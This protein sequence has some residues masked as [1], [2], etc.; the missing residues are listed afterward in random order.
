VT[1][2]NE[3]AV[4]SHLREAVQDFIQ[5]VRSEHE[6]IP[7]KVIRRVDESGHPHRETVASPSRVL[8][9]Y[10]IGAEKETPI[11][12]DAGEWL[13][14]SGN[15]F[16]ITLS[17]DDGDEIA[18]PDKDQVVLWYTNEILMLACQVMDYVGGFSY[19]ER[20]F[21]AAFEDYFKPKYEELNQYEI[22]VPLL[23]FDGPDRRVELNS[24]IDVETGDDH[25]GEISHIEISP[26]TS[27]E[28]SGI[29]TFETKMLSLGS[30]GL[31]RVSFWSHKLKF[32]VETDTGGHG[33]LENKAIDRVLT[34]LRFFK[35]DTEAVGRNK[36]YRREPNWLDFRE[37]IANVKS[38]SG[39]IYSSNLTGGSYQLEDSEVEE[40]K[41]F[42]NTY[43][44]RLVPAGD[45]NI[46]TA[47]RRFNQ[48]FS[49]ETEED[50]L[51]DCVI[52]F[53]ATLL[54]EVTHGESYRFRLPLRAALFLDEGSDYSREYIY[55][56]F[57]AIYDARSSVVHTG[58]EL[59]AQ[60][61]CGEEVRPREFVNR[62]RSFLRQTII[63][64]LD[65]EA[66]GKNVDQTNQE[67]DEAMRTASF[68]PEQL[69]EN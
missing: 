64:Y 52:G 10:R 27:N 49:K 4:K 44:Q 56:F 67:I 3:D 46:S 9:E 62:T 15:G 2:W 22:I 30:T 28:L 41:Q 47:I 36:H 8:T 37:N 29:Y 43:S 51:I 38:S 54:K 23:N 39:P 25:Q 24:D 33:G 40:F 19:S 6:E 11:L 14:D 31:N 18:N 66:E 60:E 53:E 12:R 59:G 61:I 21:E 1:D 50:Q 42:W 35:E 7:T 26:L 58:G 20:A 45:S 57:R 13:Y 32:E 16:E 69:T 65:N 34:A 55:R 5:R 48:T 68:S 63:Q 17:D